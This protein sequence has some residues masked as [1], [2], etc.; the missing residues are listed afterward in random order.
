[1]HL[2][3]KNNVVMQLID[4]VFLSSIFTKAGWL[5]LFVQCFKCWVTGMTSDALLSPAVVFRNKRRKKAEGNWLDS[6]RKRALK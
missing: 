6:P 2:M 4:F 3:Y 5:M 1:M